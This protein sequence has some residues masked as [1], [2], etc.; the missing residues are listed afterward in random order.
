MTVNEIDWNRYFTKPQVKIIKF[1]LSDY[2]L[3]SQFDYLEKPDGYEVITK[4]SKA[5]NRMSLEKVDEIMMKGE[6]D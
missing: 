2:P 5:L 6:N 4:L 3:S 1:C